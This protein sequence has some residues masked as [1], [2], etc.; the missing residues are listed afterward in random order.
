[1]HRAT[2]RLGREYTPATP[3]KP[4][5]DVLGG[6][7][8]VTLSPSPAPRIP[9]RLARTTSYPDKFLSLARVAIDKK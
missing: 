1:M 6:V 2:L 7:S 4:W 8:G 9:V 5:V 3:L